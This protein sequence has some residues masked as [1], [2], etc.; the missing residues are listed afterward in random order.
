MRRPLISR[1]LGRKLAVTCVAVV[2]FVLAYEVSMFDLRQS[3]AARP[4][5]PTLP[6]AG[7][8]VAFTATA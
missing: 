5:D 6:T 8:R 1:S 7:A 2:G 3:S 4:I